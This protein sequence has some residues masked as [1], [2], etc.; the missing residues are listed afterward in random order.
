MLDFSQ[1]AQLFSLR[2]TQTEY[3]PYAWT[4]GQ[5]MPC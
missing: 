5:R 4:V 2:I 3:Y 1:K